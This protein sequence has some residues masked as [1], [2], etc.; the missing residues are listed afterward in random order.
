MQTK[1]SNKSIISRLRRIEGQIRGIQKMVGEDRYCIDILTQ[2]TSAVAALK[3][4]EDAIM[5]RHLETCVAEAIRSWSEQEK[6]AK[7]NE[8]MDLL[9]KFRKY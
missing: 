9:A 8:V 7:I 1:N 3:G 6:Q 4:V 2:L 5:E